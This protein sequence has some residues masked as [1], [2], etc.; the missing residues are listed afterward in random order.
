[1]TSLPYH[2]R[3]A[4]GSGEPLVPASTQIMVNAAYEKPDPQTALPY[5]DALG[6][7]A[8][9]SRNPLKND[10]GYILI[11]SGPPAVYGLRSPSGEYEGTTYRPFSFRAGL[12]IT[13]LAAALLLLF[14]IM[15]F[16]YV[17]NKRHP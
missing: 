12:L 11:S 16:E 1:M 7:R 9:V 10:A 8:L 3:N 13:L 2:L 17:R 6:V 5:F 15:K 4:Y 14:G